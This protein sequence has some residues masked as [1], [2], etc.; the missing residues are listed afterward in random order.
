MT[1]S[2]HVVICIF[3]G[4]EHCAARFT[5]VLWR[6]MSDSIHVLIRRTLR[7]KLPGAG[8]AVV[9]WSPVLKSIHVLIAG[10][11][12]AKL[13]TARLALHPADVVRA[14]LV[15]GTIPHSVPR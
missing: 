13:S 6:P 3:L 8:L 11:L 4:M 1:L 10:S 7:A 14:V 9:S 12:S 5:R 2:P 15:G